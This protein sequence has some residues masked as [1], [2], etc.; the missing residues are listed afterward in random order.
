MKLSI[1]A[2]ALALS[3]PLLGCLDHDPANV[4]EAPV[5][6]EGA[7]APSIVHA[8]GVACTSAEVEER[9]AF[10]TPRAQEIEGA[11]R[12]LAEALENASLCAELRAKGSTSL[13]KELID[14]DA[15][16]KK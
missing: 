9:T 2:L 10:Y 7:P 5:A 6:V 8:A 1:A 4:E 11:A 14:L 13:K 16:T 12:P 15:K 3:I